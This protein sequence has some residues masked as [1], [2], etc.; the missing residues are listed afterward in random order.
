[1]IEEEMNTMRDKGYEKEKWRTNSKYGKGGR[2][3]EEKQRNEA[4]RGERK[5]E[6]KNKRMREK[7]YEKE[8]WRT[9]SKY[10]KGGRKGEE[11]QRNKLN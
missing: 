2:K 3:G 7:G 1:M 5:I 11:K 10:G 8:K 9:N 6:E 4:K